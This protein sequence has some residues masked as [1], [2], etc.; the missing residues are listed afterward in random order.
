MDPRTYFFIVLWRKSQFCKKSCSRAGSSAILRVRKLPKFIKNWTTVTIEENLA[1]NI[2]SI[3][4]SIILRPQPPFKI[5]PKVHR[6]LLWKPSCEKGVGPWPTSAWSP[7][8]LT[9]ISCNPS[10]CGPQPT[11]YLFIYTISTPLSI[12]LYDVYIQRFLWPDWC[13]RKTSQ[14]Y[15][16]P[17]GWA[18][19]RYCVDPDFCHRRGARSQKLQCLVLK[20]VLSF[21]IA[22]INEGD[23]GWAEW[24]DAFMGDWAGEAAG[25]KMAKGR[26]GIESEERKGGGREGEGTENWAG[27]QERERGSTD[28][29]GSLS[30]K[31]TFS[32]TWICLF[33]NVML[34]VWGLYTSIKLHFQIVLSRYAAATA[35]WTPEK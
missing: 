20:S 35:T 24:S 21:C 23:M 30:R 14:G 2:P 17:P 11:T 13:W 3:N 7:A 10:P 29:A 9:Q 6:R 27:R 16:G 33:V 18:K 31:E 8:N 15:H 26:R 22:E 5:Y 32:C 12:Y 19:G 28:E 4:F 1:K 34:T 25:R